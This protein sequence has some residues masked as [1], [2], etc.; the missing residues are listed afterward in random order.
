[1]V[2]TLVVAA[3][4]GFYAAAADAYVYWSASNNG[5]SIGR[6]NLDGTGV[7]ANFISVGSAAM[8]GLAVDSQHIY[9]TDL[10]AG[11]I[12]RANLD[13]T[14]ANDS[15]ISLAPINAGSVAVNSQYIYW[16]TPDA[17]SACN[18]GAAIGRANLDGT[19]V[20]QAF[21]CVTSSVVRGMALDSQYV[22]WGTGDSIGRANL[23]GTGANDDFIT[24]HANDV[25]VNGEYIYWND[26]EGVA[27]GR[28]NLDGTGVNQSFITTIEPNHDVDIPSSVAVDGQ[29]IYWTALSGSGGYSIGRANLDGTGV[30]TS[31]IGGLDSG[32]QSVTVDSDG[33]G[34]PRCVITIDRRCPPFTPV[35]IKGLLRSEIGTYDHKSR[36]PFVLYHH[37]YPLPFSAPTSGRAVISWYDVP[38]GA[39][40]ASAAKPVLIASGQR[41]FSAPGR[42]KI[43]LK[44]TT[45]GIKLL[46]HARR[47][48]LTA[49]GTFTRRGTRPVIATKSF[50]LTS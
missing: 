25:A 29:H 44:L 2:V 39:H 32:A 18:F 23:D 22:Y 36:I 24:V 11:T 50:T 5:Q 26:P 21:V 42:T 15:F 6:A 16:T 45:K 34:G 47:I 28:A 20:N 1:L 4:F 40:L 9:W 3:G 35:E 27:I 12:G 13:G 14:G 10:N 7:N 31:F 49:K 48:R 17:G 41:T 8:V 19:G 30:N 46:K 33:P 43:T 37:G 38:A